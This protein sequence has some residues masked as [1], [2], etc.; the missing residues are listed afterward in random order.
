LTGLIDHKESSAQLISLWNSTIPKLLS[1]DSSRTDITNS[2]NA[3]YFPKIFEFESPNSTVNDDSEKIK[4][5]FPS[6]TDLITDRIYSFA[7]IDHA[8]LQA[9]FSPVFL[10][11]ND[12]DGEFSFKEIL[13][14]SKTQ[15]DRSTFRR[16]KNW[17]KRK[18]VPGQVEP[19]ETENDLLKGNNLK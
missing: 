14:G 18:I 4:V 8:L 17:F 6:L 13:K 9:K 5:L 7:G 1:Y 19:K 12:Y 11:Y 10:Y 3:F 15:T 2:I 16:V